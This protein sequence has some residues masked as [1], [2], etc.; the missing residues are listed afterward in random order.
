MGCNAW[1]VTANGGY[2]MPGH[3]ANVWPSLKPVDLRIFEQAGRLN[4]LRSKWENRQEVTHR[5]P[6][7]AFTHLKPFCME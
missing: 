2:K 3:S 5:L 7:D 6:L 1:Y 4:T